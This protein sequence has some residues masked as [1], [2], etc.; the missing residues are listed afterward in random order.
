MKKFLLALA[1]AGAL[2]LAVSATPANAA[3]AIGLTAPA[4]ESNVE[5]VRCHHR[6][7]WSGWHCHR[8]RYYNYG[9]VQPFYVQPYYYRPYRWHRHHHHH[10]R[11]HRHW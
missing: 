11:R 1:A 10:H 2:G 6:R 4:V 3:P 9:Y 5:N 8:P 7:H